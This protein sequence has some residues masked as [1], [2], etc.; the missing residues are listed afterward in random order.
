MAS[1][2]NRK[3]FGF[4]GRGLIKGYIKVIAGSKY[5]AILG[6]CPG[7]VY[8]FLTGGESEVPRR[9]LDLHSEGL[10]TSK[11]SPEWWHVDDII[12]VLSGALL[13]YSLKCAVNWCSCINVFHRKLS[14]ILNSQ[15]SEC[16]PL[17]NHCVC[18]WGGGD[19]VNESYYKLRRA[20]IWCLYSVVFR[21]VYI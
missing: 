5:T 13:Q 6:D 12:Q 17:L 9:E 7:F 21:S 20:S 11:L 3:L 4:G 15:I 8:M 19:K 14:C 10:L 1:S 16:C 2:C 18:V